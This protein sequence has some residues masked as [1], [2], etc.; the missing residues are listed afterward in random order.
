METEEEVTEEQRKRAEANRAA[1][2]AKRKA[3]LAAPERNIHHENDHWKLFKC[4]KVSSAATANFP[5]PKQPIVAEPTGRAQRPERFRARIEI[6][7]PDSFSVTPVAIEGFTF[8]G[9]DVCVQRLTDYLSN[10]SVFRYSY[11]S[12]WK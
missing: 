8:P 3:L 11:C 2:V 5:L 1:A 10:V 4:R 12:F 6:C 7:S 9:E